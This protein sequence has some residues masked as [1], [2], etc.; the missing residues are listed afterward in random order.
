LAVFSLLVSSAFGLEQIWRCRYDDVSAI[1]QLESVNVDVQGVLSEGIVDVRIRTDMDKE[2]VNKFTSNCEVAVSDLDAQNEA[3]MALNEAARANP[4]AHLHADPAWWTA[5]HT[6]DE[7][8]SFYNNLAS[9]NPSLVRHHPAF[10]TTAQGRG[11]HAITIFDYSRGVNP[12]YKMFFTCGIHAREWIAPATCNYIADTLVETYKRGNDTLINNFTRE[13][14]LT[15]AW[16]INPDG[17]VYSWQTGGRQ[18][19][20]NR[21]TNPGSSC[22]GVDCNRNFNDHWNGGGSSS[23]PCSDTFMGQSAASENEVR[24]VQSLFAEAQRSAPIIGAIDWH[25]YSQLI[26]RP[27]GWTNSLC[28]DETVLSQIGNKMRDDIAGVHGKAYTSQRSYQLYQTSGSASDYY[29][30]TIATN[31]NGNFKIA[32]YTIELR[33]GSNNSTVGFNLPPAEILPTGQE[34]WAAMRNY[35]NTLRTTPIRK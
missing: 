14:E 18:W 16:D 27:Y 35:F 6:Y 31:A 9:S 10:A 23:D 17:Y 8:R 32:S 15:V 28:P 19:R 20:K 5:Y 34:N 7:L 24:G 13:V 33:P 21:K 1:Q 25:S 29:Y 4:R 12:T 22:I 3:F 26:L 30:G 2:Y 11:L